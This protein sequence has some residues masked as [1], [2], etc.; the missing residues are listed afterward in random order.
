MLGTKRKKKDYVGYKITKCF[1]QYVM[2]LGV[3]TFSAN[4]CTQGTDTYVDVLV[5]FQNDCSLER[6]EIVNSR[7][8]SLRR[9]FNNPAF[10]KLFS[11]G[12]HFH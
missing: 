6:E 8:T 7:R 4:V 1:M 12:D 5:E 10:L 11:S 3:V 9:E 2:L